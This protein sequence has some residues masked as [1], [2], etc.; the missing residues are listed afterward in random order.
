MQR[1][2]YHAGVENNP[3]QPIWIEALKTDSKVNANTSNERD[4]LRMKPSKTHELMTQSL[5][6]ISWW[7]LMLHETLKTN[8]GPSNK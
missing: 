7:L 5:L 8:I 1:G 4:I 2:L 6:D 3:E